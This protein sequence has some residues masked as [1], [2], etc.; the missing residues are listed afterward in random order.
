MDELFFER[1]AVL[2]GA[3]A[4]AAIFTP[5]ATLAASGDL[6]SIRKAITAGH[7]ATVQRLQEWIRMPSI[8]AENRDMD[9]GCD[10]MMRLARDAGFQT[11]EKIPTKGHP[12]V[13]AVLDAG[14]KKT[15]GIYFMYD[16]KQYDPAEWSVPPIEA[17]LVDKPGFGK[18]VM[19]R[20]AVNQKGPEATFLAA[21]HAF[22]ASGRK[23]PVNLV[24]VAEGEEEIGSPNFNDIVRTPRV[25]AALKKCVGVIIPSGWQSPTTGGVAVNLGAKGMIEFELVASGK[26]WGRGPEKDI[27]SSQKANVDSPA[28]R[29]IAA[30]ST[31]VTPDGNMP[32]VN[33][34]M[35]NVRPLTAREKAL[36]AEA[37]RNLSEADAK[38]QLGVQRWIDDMSWPQSLER[39]ASVPTINIEGLVSGYTGPGGKT[40]LPGRAVAKIDCRLVPNQTREEAVAKIRAH[41]DAKGFKDVEMNVSGGYDPTETAEDSSLV[42]AELA[43]YA[44]HKVP[45]SVYPRLAG[46]WPG[47]VFTGQPVGLPAGQFG[48]GHGSGAHAPDEYFVIDSSNP[49]VAG[50]DDAAMGFV[51]FLYEI[52]A[53]G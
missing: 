49:K 31:L 20:G 46:S 25:L 47:V 4:G 51:D 9:K 41:L 29:L 13:F 16:V 1:R 6:A 52:A 48:L 42:K 26:A 14:A 22:K 8:A 2:R 40:I 18:V 45:T 17:R 10:H 28:W 21:V 39:L 50:I 15:M 5:G 43:T 33:G 12:G 19:G 3:A 34:Y 11:V 37:A 44:R 24:L 27:H 30:L 7:D 36:L 23:L 53:I 35:D 32:A 38:R